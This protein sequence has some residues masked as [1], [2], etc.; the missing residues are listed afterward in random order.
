MKSTFEIT[1]VDLSDNMLNVSR[2]LNPECV[3]VQGDMR[4]I[5]L[6]RE[7]D[8]VFIHDAISHM[9]S[10]DDLCKAIDTAYKHCRKG[11]VALFCP[12][13]T[14]ET[15]TS[16]TAT[17]GTDLGDRGLRYLEWT[18]PDDSA[19]NSYSMYMIYLFRTAGGVVRSELDRMRCGLFKQEDWLAFLS[20]GGFTPE[21]LRYPDPSE[22]ANPYMFLGVK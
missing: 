1:L 22:H 7:F 10:K 19:I 16:T 18:L 20:N 14:Y 3:H 2:R 17:G 4:A 11:G 13:Y 21:I 12:D 5:S 8:S 15:F 9:I 6:G